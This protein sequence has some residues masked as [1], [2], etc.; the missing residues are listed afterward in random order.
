MLIALAI[1]WPE[2]SDQVRW[3]SRLRCGSEVGGSPLAMAP[4]GRL[5]S[6]VEIL[7]SITLVRPHVGGLVAAEV[8]E[9]LPADEAPRRARPAAQ[10]DRVGLALAGRVEDEPEER[11]RRPSPARLARYDGRTMLWPKR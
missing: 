9:R 6:G 5:N 4:S 10:V 1:A 11:L 7:V 2:G 3:R 8:E